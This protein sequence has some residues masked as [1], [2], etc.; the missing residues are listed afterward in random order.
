MAN[1]IYTTDNPIV[2]QIDILSDTMYYKD[3]AILLNIIPKIYHRD[4]LR[5]I[6]DG[7]GCLCYSKREKIVNNKMYICK[8]SVLHIS[9]ASKEF[10]DELNIVLLKGYGK[11]GIG[12]GCFVLRITN[13]TKILEI[14]EYIYENK[15]ESLFLERKY[16]KYISIRNFE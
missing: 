4:Y 7:D 10:L 6:I 14:C 5:G 2:K 15:D 9:S 1:K 13:R 16:K 3:I 8:D 12:S 11:I